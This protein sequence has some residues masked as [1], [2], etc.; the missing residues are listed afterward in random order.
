[1]FKYNKVNDHEI[2]IS[3]FPYIIS[4]A[5][6][7]VSALSF[8]LII[9]KQLDI[10]IGLAIILVCLVILFSL[11]KK[12]TNINFQTHKVSHYKRNMFSKQHAMIDI[13]EVK[14]IR[15]ESKFKYEI[16]T[17]IALLDTMNKKHVIIDFDLIKQEPKNLAFDDLK[18]ELLNH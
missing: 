10:F 9:A 17:K 14:V 3:D 11:T 7:G 15:L 5:L 18:K 1:M 16:F 6:A 8:I 13:N 2:Q 4:F 12:D